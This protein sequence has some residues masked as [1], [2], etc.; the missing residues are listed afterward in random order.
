MKWPDD[1]INKIIC[2]DALEILPEIPDKSVD[3]IITDPVWP[4]SRVDLPGRHNSVEILR[5][6]ATHFARITDRV[7]IHFGQMTDP[8]HLV[9]IPPELPF[10]Q[11]CWLRWIPVR[12]QGPVMVGSDVVYVFGHKKLPGDGSKVFGGECNHVTNVHDKYGLDNRNDAKCKHPTPRSFVHTNWLIKRFSRPGD[13][14]LDPFC[15][16]GT[17]CKAARVNGRQFIGIDTK[18]E[19]ADYARES[20]ESSK[21]VGVQGRIKI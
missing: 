5:E 14:I 2:G 6:A 10:V 16:S 20:V 12:Y 3:S 4:G 18:Q 17:T 21:M 19:F 15:G 13:I 1:Y 11:V 9:V 7:I 8:R